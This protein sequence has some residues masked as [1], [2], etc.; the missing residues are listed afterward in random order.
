M[1]KREWRWLWL[2]VLFCCVWLPPGARGET[3]TVATASN[4]V[5]PLQKLAARFE[6]E[7]GVKVV[8]V[9]GSSGNLAAQIAKR[10][11]YD[12]F[13]AADT[14]G[15]ARLHRAGRCGEPFPYATGEL[16]LW[17]AQDL[18]PA[19]DW[20][21][22]LRGHRGE[23]L[24]V[25]N[26]ANAPYGAAAR[27]VLVKAELWEQ[28]RDRLIYAQNVGQAFQLAYQGSAELAMVSLSYALSGKGREGV[29]YSIPEAPLLV[30]H[31]CVVRRSKH[32]KLAERFRQFLAGE[33]GR[34]MMQK[35]GYEA[36]TARV[37]EKR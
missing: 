36:A 18:E 27:D 28:M 30:Q 21:G 13:L 17:I 5:L 33:T 9:S 29:Y 16:V 1:G 35:Y 23:R 31:G 7:Q 25:A 22:A 4:F 12:L 14:A 19:V 32:K 26:P 6:Q 20:Q 11:P 8:V 10:A 24:A 2:G 37:E 15:P 3:L 34:A